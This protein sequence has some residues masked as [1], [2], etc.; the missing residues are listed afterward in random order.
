MFVFLGGRL[1]LDPFF[2]RDMITVLIA[3]ISIGIVMMAIIIGTTT[4]PA[5][6]ASGRSE[7]I[8]RF[9]KTPPVF[10]CRFLHIKIQIFFI[11]YRA[12]SIIFGT[13]CNNLVDLSTSYY[14][15]NL[16]ALARQYIIQLQIF[17]L[18]LK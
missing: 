8:L 3:R 12:L 15:L 5:I 10:I 7:P 13:I 1:F 11:S 6:T 9:F 18:F 2:V 17:H 4:S 16:G 14:I